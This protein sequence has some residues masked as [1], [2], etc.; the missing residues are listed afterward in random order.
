MAR[1]AASAMDRKAGI[2][3]GLN[4]EVQPQAPVNTAVTSPGFGA[5]DGDVDKAV[6]SPRL[7]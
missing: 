6:D 4:H 3:D 5:M 2:G 7:I 1:R